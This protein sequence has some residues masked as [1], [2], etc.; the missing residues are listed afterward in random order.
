MTAEK[1]LV[2]SSKDPLI[3]EQAWYHGNDTQGYA[4]LVDGRIVGVCYFWYGKTYLKRNFWPLAE[5]EAKLVQIVTIPEM[6]GHGV[7]AGL[8]ASAANDMFDRG[9]HCLYARIWHSNAPSARAFQRA[10]WRHVA[11]VIEVYPLRRQAPFRI[12]RRGVQEAVK[13]KK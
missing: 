7:A 11:T 8:I 1:A 5:G 9:F 6:R 4:C 13:V 3:S 2:E 12:T 10:G